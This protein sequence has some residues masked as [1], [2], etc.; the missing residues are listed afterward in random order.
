[1]D[2][3]DE[4]SAE[5]EALIARVGAGDKDAF[6]N[7]YDAT[8]PHLLGLCLKILGNRRSAEKVLEQVYIGLRQMAATYPASGY[9]PMTWLMTLARNLAVD[10]LRSGKTR[11]KLPR[12]GKIKPGTGPLATCLD[13]LEEGPGD[14]I[15]TAYLSAA[16][17]EDLSKRYDIPMNTVD[18]WMRRNLLKLNT[19]LNT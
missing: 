11:A 5:L 12:K 14:A 1:M 2:I 9:Q 7:L 4:V 18:T 6:I 16:T 17:Y 8:A 15:A 3:S 10:E 19:C 13:Q